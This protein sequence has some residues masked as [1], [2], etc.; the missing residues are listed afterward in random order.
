[1]ITR[2]S[3]RTV[4]PISKCLPEPIASIRGVSGTQKLTPWKENRMLCFGVT[5]WIKPLLLLPF[6]SMAQTLNIKA[7]LLWLPNPDPIPLPAPVW[8]FK[9]LH[10]LT[11]SLH[12]T[13]VHL[14]IGGLLIGLV[15]NF[16]GRRDPGSHYAQA[17]NEIASRLPIVMTFLI[18]FGVPPLLFTQVLYGRAIY[19]SSILI[20]AY[21]ISV[22]FLLMAGYFLLYQCAKYA[23]TKRPWWLHGITALVLLGFIARIYTTNFTLML[24]PVVWLDLYRADA[25]GTTLPGGDPTIL[26][27]WLFMM[28]ASLAFTGVALLLLG[29]N[30]PQLTSPVSKFLTRAGALVAAV[31]LPIQFLIGYWV[32]QVQPFTVRTE[33]GQAQFY[34]IAMTGWPVL[35]FLTLI[36]ALL[37]N[38]FRMLAY[39]S[40]LFGFLTVSVS[41]IVR[42]GIRDFTLMENGFNVW[43][44]VVVPNW[45]IV[46]LFLTLFVA[47]LATIGWLVNIAMSAKNEEGVAHTHV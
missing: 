40:A 32:L 33:L 29:Q 26:P 14:V 5:T 11:L 4:L 17:S 8:L 7:T 47:G 25:L 42:D 23:E 30:T 6:T 45:Q 9:T 39:G 36:S 21:W 2:F 34:H 43:H 18:N 46:I 31:T 44:Q 35:L 41:V 15:W 12:F 3:F 37:A 28:V 24:K 19:T 1:M 10:I 20:G 38:R 16:L 22:I 13:T 27:R